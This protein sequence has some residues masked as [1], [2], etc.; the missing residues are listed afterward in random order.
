MFLCLQQQV[1][2]HDYFSIGYFKGKDL[3]WRPAMKMY[4]G[5]F[6]VFFMIG[7]LGINVR[8]WNDNGVNHVLIFELDPRHHLKYVD[9]LMVSD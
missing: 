8:V 7:L 1:K 3:N 6:L 5:L 4:R 2:F 9:I